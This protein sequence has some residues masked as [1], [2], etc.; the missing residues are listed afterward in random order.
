MRCIENSVK[1][2]EK[3]GDSEGNEDTNNNKYNIYF[4][5]LEKD[6][7]NILIIIKT[8]MKK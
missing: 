2:T 8:A 5:L 1:N 3:K 4:Y 6:K 7:K